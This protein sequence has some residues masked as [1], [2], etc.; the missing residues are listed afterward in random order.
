MIKALIIEN[1]PPV[2]DYLV[3]LLQ[4]NFAD[5]EVVAVCDTIASSLEAIRLYQP[6]LVFLDVELNPPETGFDI[7]RKLASIDFK[8]IFT[9]AYNQYAIPAI[10]F[11]ALDY[12]LKPIDEEQLQQAV[13]K[14]LHEKSATSI[15]QRDS[16][17]SYNHGYDHAKIGLP[18][19][20]GY[21]L[22]FV[23]D[24]LYCQGESSQ[25][26]IYMADKKQIVVNRTLK[27]CEE[28]LEKFG[29]C[30]I[31]KSY[32]VNVEYIKEYHRG[33]G[34]Y[35]VLANGTNLDVSKN[36]KEELLL[37]LKKL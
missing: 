20:G 17:L 12:L 21:S 10:K 4:R 22:V 23:R 28:M 6:D 14:Y 7:L 35:V 25:A 8:V 15:L 18:T 1:E 24:I 26:S 19:V 27:E 34:G 13:K 37:R 30:R 36:Y 16:L 5:V 9:T 32:L 11:S 3:T 2:S 33:D 31:H 29:F